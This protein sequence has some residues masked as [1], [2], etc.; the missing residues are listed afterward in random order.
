MEGKGGT[1]PTLPAALGHSTPKREA[2]RSP[3][4]PPNSTPQRQER[5]EQKQRGGGLAWTLDGTD[6][7]SY[8]VPSVA[9][10]KKGPENRHRELTLEE[11]ETD[12]STGK[13]RGEGRKKE[14]EERPRRKTKQ[15][16][17]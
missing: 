5:Q 13:P 10:F 4:N 14:E 6:H 17:K 16:K 3:H 9:K 7:P 1:T 11:R 2:D 8:I 15:W 12:T